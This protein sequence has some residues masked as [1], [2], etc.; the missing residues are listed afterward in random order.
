MKR[1]VINREKYNLKNAAPYLTAFFVPVIVLLIIF[2]EKG[3]APFGDQ[4]FLRTD[5]YHQ[6]AP[7]FRELKRKLSEGGSLF[8][9]W[10]IGSGTNY[11]AIV[12]Y[13]LASPLNVLI[14]LWPRDCIIEFI[15]FMIVNKLALCSLTLTY[16]LN[17]K[18]DKHGING[19]PAAFFGIFYALSGY[20]AAYNWN[21]MWLDCIWLFPLVILGLERLVKE[22]KGLLYAV[23][24]GFTVL[25]NYYIA[26]MVSMGI[27]CYCFFLLGTE[28]EMVKN[29]GI[30]LLKFIGYTALGLAFSAVIL[31]PYV[32]YFGMTAS[33]TGNFTW[34]W[35]R[36]YFSIFDM[37]SRHLANV[38]T[39]TGLDHWPNIYCGVAVFL[40]VPM[41]Y[42]NKRISLREKLGYTILLLFFYF[43]FSSRTMDYIWHGFHIPNS[44]PC[45]Q[46]FIYIFILLT[47]SYRGFLGLKERSYRDIT[48]CLLA[49]LI[50]TFL[51]EKFETDTTYY[52]NYV[53]YGS[54]IFMII[55]TVIIYAMRRGRTGRDILIVLLI[56]T[57]ALETCIDT[58]V[59]SVST[60][61]RYE[62]TNYDQAMEEILPEI[63]EKE[64]GDFYRVEK[65]SNRTKNDGAWLGYHTISTFS[66]VANANLSHFYTTLGL[67]ASTNAYGSL[68]QTP[69]TEMFFGIRYLV[70]QKELPKA[71]HLYTLFDMRTTTSGS[72]SSA[73]Q[74]TTYVYRTN[75]A[76]P[77]G[78]MI[79]SAALSGW[80]DEGKTPLENQNQL[81]ALVAGTQEL[82]VDVTPV[83]TSDKTVKMTIPS[84]GFYFAYSPKAGPKEIQA[85][86][87]G[88]S[89]KFQNL[90]RCFVMDLSY[91]EQGDELTF[92]N[93]EKDSAKLLDITLYRLQDDKIPEIYA[94]F[95]ESPLVVT[96]FSDTSLEGEIDVKKAGTLLLTIG[97]EEGWEAYVDG[98]KAEII[99]AKEALI[100]LPLSEGH[101]SIRLKYHV[102]YFT[103]G[104]LLT[105]F[106][107]LLMIGI[108]VG[109]LLIQRQKEKRFD[110]LV[111]T[112]EAESE[113]TAFA[114]EN[115]AA[116]DNQDAMS[117][118]D[119]A[120][121]S[122]PQN[123]GSETGQDQLE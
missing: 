77:V 109:N 100:S 115:A 5:L 40:F 86:H 8:Y 84:D 51:A 108:F 13:Y 123:D 89:K 95:S 119:T 6:Y 118:V 35:G 52:G 78:F 96:D 107:G 49:A 104:L 33:A 61:S 71:D 82:Y 68:G 45:R 11:W 12:A 87:P 3:I 83:Y 55:Y 67:E 98:E 32:A 110:R 106:S 75:Y 54:A 28:P 92:E 7:F 85:S 74:Y 101:H 116:T 117:A 105:I 79:D 91:C 4:C 90:N 1:P 42:L 39:H 111:Q 70:S 18:H 69:F 22:N 25:S 20:M 10:N 21:V 15:T 114:P 94:A 81:A 14:V 29:F 73:H 64:N 34:E 88:F 76:L 48:F 62:Y 103:L 60:V 63:K 30:K 44:L 9:S 46:A 120:V 99:E 26:I 53:F 66:S 43:S 102:P 41:Y 121:A 24:F 57:A 97:N 23:T 80:S 47:V 38:D 122:E 58:T 19:F 50:F 59:T 112:G 16:Y 56:A 37:L 113:E 27:A 2:I 36:T 65:V 31:I 72:G 17:K 93:V